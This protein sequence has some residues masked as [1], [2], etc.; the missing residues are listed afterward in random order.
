[1]SVEENKAIVKRLFDELNK[2][3]VDAAQ[4]LYA[5][6]FGHHWHAGTKSLGDLYPK[7]L[8]AKITVDDIMAEG[9][10]VAAWVTWENEKGEHLLCFVYRLSG[11]KIAE[12]WN[13]HHHLTGRGPA[14]I[15]P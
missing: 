3:N 11:G 8:G 12:S 2:G 6:D 14:K 10:R 15:N 5:P 9:D 13:M 1:M 4:E 7:H